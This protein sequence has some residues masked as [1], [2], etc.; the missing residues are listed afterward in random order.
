MKA[1][2]ELVSKNPNAE[3]LWASPREMLNI[4]QADAC[5]C[6]II[7]VVDDI[8]KKAGMVGM[9]LRE[10][11]LETVKMFYRDAT[12]SGFSIN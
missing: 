12:S 8:L 11:S 5:G 3:L 10:L 7:T 9:D 1:A 4:I 2:L 6:H